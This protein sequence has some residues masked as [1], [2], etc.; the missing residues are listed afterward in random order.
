MVN[1]LGTRSRSSKGAVLVQAV[2]VLVLLFAI[3]VGGTLLLVDS[4]I[5]MLCQTKLKFVADQCAYFAQNLNKTEDIASDT[6]IFGR[7]LAAKMGFNANA[8]SVQVHEDAVSGKVTVQLTQQVSLLGDGTIL[9]IVIPIN[10]CSSAPRRETASGP[11]AFKGKALLTFNRN[12]I[13]VWVP[14]LDVDEVRTPRREARYNAIPG[15]KLA[16]TLGNGGVVD[17]N[18]AAEAERKK[19]HDP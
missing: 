2:M 18:G 11:T 3:L 9:P 15:N 7:D 17:F 4:G 6:E 10:V 14:I 5:S 8:L 12:S 19:S 1:R 13:G 16:V